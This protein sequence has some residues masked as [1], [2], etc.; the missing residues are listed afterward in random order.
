MYDGMLC[1]I[2]P[3]HHHPHHHVSLLITSNKKDLALFGSIL[4]AISTICWFAFALFRGWVSTKYKGR[5]R[6]G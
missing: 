6:R 3:H 5:R 4:S 2:L 1:I